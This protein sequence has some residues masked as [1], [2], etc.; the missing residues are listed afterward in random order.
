M[1]AGR[2]E[3]AAHLAR[4]LGEVLLRDARPLLEQVAE[5]AAVH[6]LHRDRDKSVLKVPWG[7]DRC[8]MIREYSAAS[9]ATMSAM[10]AYMPCDPAL[11]PFAGQH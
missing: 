11:P 8:S 10:C 1:R 7:P 3:R 4:H 5:R 2:E 9:A 6:V